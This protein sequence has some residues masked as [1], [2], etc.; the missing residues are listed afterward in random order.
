MTLVASSE[1]RKCKRVNNG[2]RNPSVVVVWV[3]VL[4]GLGAVLSVALA[5]TVLRA[6]TAR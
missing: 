2:Y 5:R 1:H 3:S 6:R 4:I